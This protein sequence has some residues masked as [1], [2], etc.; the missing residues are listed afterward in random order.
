MKRESIQGQLTYSQTLNVN[1]MVYRLKPEDS[2]CDF[3]AKMLSQNAIEGILKYHYFGLDGKRELRFEL[4]G[5]VSLEVYLSQKEPTPETL[6]QI[7]LQVLDIL[8]RGESFLL[9]YE[10][11]LMAI[12]HTYIDLST[13]RI[14]LVYMPVILGSQNQDM[15]LNEYI[16]SILYGF[17]GKMMPELS[18][19]VGNLNGLLREPYP[20]FDR[21]RKI[22]MATIGG[23]K[24]CDVK[25][26]QVQ[27][28]VADVSKIERQPELKM[29][30]PAFKS[31]NPSQPKGQIINDKKP[32][33]VMTAWIAMLLLNLVLTLLILWGWR[34]LF[35][36]TG[37]FMSSIMAIFLL[38]VP[39]NFY[40]LK[41]FRRLNKN[42]K[43]DKFSL[44][45]TQE[46][47]IA[48]KKVV[49]FSQVK[50]SERIVAPNPAGME[51]R[52]GS[53]S[54]EG[55]LEP[56]I[57]TQG[58]VLSKKTE[59]LSEERNTMAYLVESGSG[60][61]ILLGKERFIIGRQRD[62]V[63]LCLSDSTIGRIH[64]EIKQSEED[65]VV[66]DLNSKNGTRVNDERLVSNVPF[67][68]KEG[69]CVVFSNKAFYFR[70][71]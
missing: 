15:W 18:I 32:R 3:Q 60:E 50:S 19:L 69:D 5:L 49:P 20:S 17:R 37:G 2:W 62:L 53:M 27:K 10:R 47:K 28:V 25:H 40:G 59:L 1:Y 52:V 56:P 66:V 41:A 48:D 57:M 42:E 23:V 44:H 29:D 7:I 6:A 30:K 64:A 68:L 24:L 34:G 51:N 22:L 46:K 13:M 33:T 8:S 16:Q 39:I 26:L 45:P 4:S 11:F 38:A 43:S 12:E 71:H 54:R 35:E 58:S 9:D 55:Q 67:A 31:I 63:D 65:T 14:Y 70:T 36:M 21:M 61:R